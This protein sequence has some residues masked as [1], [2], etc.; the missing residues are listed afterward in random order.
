MAIMRRQALHN[1]QLSII[2]SQ[3]K[4]WYVPKGYDR[5][6][7]LTNKDHTFTSN[8]TFGVR[9]F[10]IYSVLYRG[11]YRFGSDSLK[12]SYLACQCVYLVGRSVNSDAYDAQA[13]ITVRHAHSSDYVL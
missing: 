5:T 13:F 1:Y 6:I 2:N 8:K 9:R 3:L 10:M 11:I 4:K 12:S 7:A